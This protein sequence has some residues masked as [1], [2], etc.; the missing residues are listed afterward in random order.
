MTN[1]ET[2]WTNFGLASLL[3]KDEFYGIDSNYWRGPIWININFMVLRGLKLFYWEAPGVQDI[4]NSLRNN[5][6]ANVCG[7]FEER[8]YIFEHYNQEYDGTGHGNHPFNGWSSLI[9]LIINED[10]S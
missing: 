10:Y 1:P 9:S 8:G 7:K 5:I 6:I 2:I 3:K 4:Y